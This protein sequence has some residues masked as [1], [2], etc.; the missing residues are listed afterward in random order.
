MGEEEAEEEEPKKSLYISPLADPVISDKLL[1][2]SLKL[3]KKAVGE[4][5]AR[6]GVPEC[7]KAVRKGQQGIIFLAGDIPH[8]RLRPCPRPVRGEGR[9]LLLREV[10]SRA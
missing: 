1:D 8:G 7:V 4:K 9:V 10:S 3:I 2:R 6:R 5:K